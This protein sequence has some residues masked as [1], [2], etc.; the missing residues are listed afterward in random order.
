MHYVAGI[1]P[2]AQHWLLGM[3]CIRWC[4]TVMC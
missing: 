1:H 3:W 2:M 4:I